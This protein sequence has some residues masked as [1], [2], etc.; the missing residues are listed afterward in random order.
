MIKSLA[1]WVH[2]TFYQ[3]E[4]QSAL[5]TS[6]TWTPWEVK[7]A[8]LGTHHPTSL[9]LSLEN[10]WSASSTSLMC[11]SRTHES[12]RRYVYL[13]VNCIKYNHLA[14]NLLS[15]PGS[16]HGGDKYSEFTLDCRLR[17]EDAVFLSDGRQ[18]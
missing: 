17:F 16:I 7:T 3:I 8:D 5:G 2:S 11:S 4:Y 6:G 14:L 9:V 18:W 13:I 1:L 10:M 12:H 15:I